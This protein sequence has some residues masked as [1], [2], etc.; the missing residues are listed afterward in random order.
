MEPRKLTPLK[1]IRP[2]GK[3][4]SQIQEIICF[5]NENYDIRVNCF[6]PS[7]SQIKSKKKQYA[8]PPSFDD[9]SLHCTDAG[10]SVGDTI[11]RKILR[12]PNQV[13]TYNPITE[14]FES[15]RKQYKGESHID[16]LLSHLTARDFGDK[17]E[18]YYQARMNRI[19]RKWLVATV[20]CALGKHPNEVALGFIQREEGVGKTYLTRFLVPDPLKEFYV[21]SQNPSKNFVM[22]DA[23]AK[24]LVVNFDELVGISNRTADDFK[25]TLSAQFLTV[26]HYRDPYPMT[27]PRIGSAMFTSNRTE[28]L[29][30]FITANM[31]TRRFAC[32]ELDGIDQHYSTK[33]NLDQ[34]WAEAV[35]L[36]DQ[37]AFDY[38]FLVEDFLEFKTYNNRY[39]EQT[40]ALRLIETY[41]QKPTTEEEGEWLQPQQILQ[42]MVKSRLIPAGDRPFVTSQKIGE[43][44]KQL[45]FD[46]KSIRLPGIGTRYAYH[47]MRV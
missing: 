28:E 27:V 30:G 45:N 29:G 37:E 41:F 14:Y 18:G 16:L 3:G 38:K 40:S 23:F 26:K 32:I 10:I 24:N 25:Q 17:E 35:M 1:T 15:L 20:A 46:R 12:S 11:L 42:E 19:V 43:A 36:L 7:R 44:L 31:G 9:I 47:V 13:S 33:V 21:V 34:L 8:Y 2:A 5:L 39:R 4:S 6:D 22:E